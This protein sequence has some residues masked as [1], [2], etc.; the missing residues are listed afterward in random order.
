MQKEIA[1]AAQFLVAYV[2]R[3]YSAIIKL[4]GF[5]EPVELDVL[6]DNTDQ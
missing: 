4:L 2:T 5:I 3:E 6:C 1:C